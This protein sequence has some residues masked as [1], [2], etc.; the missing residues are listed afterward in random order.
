[1]SVDYHMV[2]SYGFPIGRAIDEDKDE[3]LLR[4]FREKGVCYCTDGN[5]FT[6][7]LEDYVCIKSMLVNLPSFDDR[8]KRI[9]IPSMILDEEI[10]I[11]EEKAEQFGVPDEKIDW[12][13]IGMI[14]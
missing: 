2:I 11:L 5:G 12:Y 8:E 14:F 10:N 4:D 13:F 7:D 9:K 3:E 1:M 6:G